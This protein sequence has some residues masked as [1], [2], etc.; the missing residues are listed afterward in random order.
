MTARVTGLDRENSTGRVGEIFAKSVKEFGTVSNF[1]KIMALAPG[2]LEA[3]MTAN[4]GIRMRYLD[5]DLEFLKVEQAAIIRTSSQN[6]SEY[7]LLHNIDLGAEAGL[8]AEQ[9]KMIQADDYES[10]DCLDERTKATI[11]WI[12][13]V[14]D[15]T[16]SGDEDA[17]QRMTTH[18]SEQQ[19]VELTV[20]CCMWN[21]SN[22]F[23]EAFH[24]P[25]EPEGKRLR[26][27][28]L[29]VT[30]AAE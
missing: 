28:P 26:F 6:Q 17:F 1:S 12:D 11:T 23:T 2:A 14:T 27:H 7:C 21:F 13:A 3:W 20:L 24:I 5:E 4:R 30:A 19:I 10:A 16:A 18:F 9:I 15:M 8:T 29:P 25:P 22:R